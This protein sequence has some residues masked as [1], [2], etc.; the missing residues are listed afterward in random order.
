MGIP[1]DFQTPESQEDNI[2][3]LNEMS[4]RGSHKV[5]VTFECCFD[6]TQ[7][8]RPP[9][10]PQPQIEMLGCVRNEL[11][12]RGGGGVLTSDCLTRKW[13]FRI[14]VISYRV[15]MKKHLSS[16]HVHLGSSEAN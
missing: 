7:I 16:P 9:P 6:V 13:E 12:G 4:C 1:L 10:H 5:K 14:H 3:L 2:L 11:E 8:P 15:Y